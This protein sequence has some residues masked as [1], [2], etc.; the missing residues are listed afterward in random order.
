MST[1]DWESVARELAGALDSCTT[2]I[3]QMKGM[4]PDDDGL[5]EQALQEAE[6][7]NEVFAD[8]VAGTP[9][10]GFYTHFKSALTEGGPDA[11]EKSSGGVPC[12]RFAVQEEDVAMFPE[13]AN[14]DSVLVWNGGIETS[15]PLPSVI[16]ET[17]PG[18]RDVASMM[19]LSTGQP[20]EVDEALVQ[21]IAGKIR[22]AGD[23]L[24]LDEVIQEVFAGRASEVNNQGLETQIRY[25]LT[26]G[27][28]EPGILA[29]AD[30]SN[31]SCR[32]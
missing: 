4:F 11:W 22:D 31:P 20:A 5:I 1:I 19:A 27:E 28:D 10:P 6:D 24:A 17:A 12:G 29:K 26:A 18:A 8:A 16:N 30:I 7:A 23:V 15:P 2:Q 21:S 14:V 9:K 13:L 25:L 32:R 3:E